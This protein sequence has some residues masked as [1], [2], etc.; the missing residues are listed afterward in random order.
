MSFEYPRYLCGEGAHRMCKLVLK[1]CV[2]VNE[3]GAETNC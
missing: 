1:G 3:L 2:L